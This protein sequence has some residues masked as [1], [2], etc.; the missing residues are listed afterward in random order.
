M[1]PSLAIERSLWKILQKTEYRK[2][3]P[4][5]VMNKGRFLPNPSCLFSHK[6]RFKSFRTSQPIGITRLG[7]PG[8]RRSRMVEFLKSTSQSNIPS[9]SRSFTPVPY[10]KRRSVLRALG[11]S[12]QVA[13]R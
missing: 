5:V 13:D 7:E 3:A 10:R 8:L 4:F 2:Q 1:G 11:V 12:V 9:A 6:R